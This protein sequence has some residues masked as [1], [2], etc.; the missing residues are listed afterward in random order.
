MHRGVGSGVRAALAHLILE[1]VGLRSYYGIQFDGIGQSLTCSVNCYGDVQ[2]QR[3]LSRKEVEANLRF[4]ELDD[5]FKA[6]EKSHEMFDGAPRGKNWSDR[7]RLLNG[8]II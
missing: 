4:D 7:L 3:P 5:Y 8:L 1:S 6:E 2:I